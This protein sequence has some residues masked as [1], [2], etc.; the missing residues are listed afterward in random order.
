MVLF[1]RLIMAKIVST[2]SSDCKDCFDRGVIFFNSR[3]Y[4]FVFFFCYLQ[5]STLCVYIGTQACI[6]VVIVFSSSLS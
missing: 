2:S 5:V 4:L 3:I 1:K 6:C